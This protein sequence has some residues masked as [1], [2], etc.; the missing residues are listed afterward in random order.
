MDK[1]T[2]RF[3]IV[4]DDPLSIMVTETYIRKASKQSEIRSFTFGAF[5]LK[6]LEEEYKNIPENISTL[7]LLDLYMPMMN[8]FEF[9]EHFE[10]LPIIKAKIKIVTLSVLLDKQEKQK[11]M[12]YPHVTEYY[13]KP[14]TREVLNDL[15][16]KNGFFV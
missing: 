5:A 2:G 10:K 15:I 1:A 11:V 12:Q 3:I 7:L 14:I 8:G 9:L 6:Y 4:D 16:A 13:A